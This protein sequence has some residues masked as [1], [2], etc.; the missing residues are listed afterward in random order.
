MNQTEMNQV[1]SETNPYHYMISDSGIPDFTS[2]FSDLLEK[3]VALPFDDDTKHDIKNLVVYMV[4]RPL[5]W[6]A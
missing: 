4:M 6:R 2:V 3:V 1:F 5:K